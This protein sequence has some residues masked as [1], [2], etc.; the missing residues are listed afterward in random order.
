M[1]QADGTTWTRY[2]SL[3]YGPNNGAGGKVTTWTMLRRAGM[4]VAA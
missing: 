3:Y 1:V 4:V 2:G